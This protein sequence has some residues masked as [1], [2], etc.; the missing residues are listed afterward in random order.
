M[1]ITR[2]TYDIVYCATKASTDNSQGNQ[3]TIESCFQACESYSYATYRANLDSG[4][5]NCWCNVQDPMA[6]VEVEEGNCGPDVPIIFYHR[7]GAT[8]PNPNPIQWARRQLKEMFEV[9]QQLWRT[10][11]SPIGFN[12]CRIAEGSDQYEV[13]L[14]PIACPCTRNF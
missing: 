5:Y 8:A 3:P 1:W 9:A 11:S 6:E 12:A 7:A 4:A 2:T 10:R 13:R 14:A